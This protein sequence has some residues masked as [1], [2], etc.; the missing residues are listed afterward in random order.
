MKDTGIA[1]RTA[2][3]LCANQ[4][5]LPSPDVLRKICNTYQIQPNE[6]LE[7]L[8]ESEFNEKFKTVK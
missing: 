4:T 8:P 7:W 5:Q 3:D 2:Y 1:Q 6:I